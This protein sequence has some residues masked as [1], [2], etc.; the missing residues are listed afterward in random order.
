MELKA[1][2]SRTSALPDILSTSL[3]ALK[4]SADAFPPLKGAVGGVLAVWD[5][6]QVGQPHLSGVI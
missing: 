2:S 6:A 4:E 5:V 1:F 3:F